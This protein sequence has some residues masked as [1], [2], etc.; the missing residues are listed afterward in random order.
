MLRV[1]L[2][3]E[4]AFSSGRVRGGAFEAWLQGLSS[5]GFE[6]VIS[7]SRSF[8]SFSEKVFER[9]PIGEVNSWVCLPKRFSSRRVP[10]GA[11]EAWFRGLSS[12]G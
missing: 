8:Q 6:D 12:F 3:P 2:S 11:F 1:G 7:L 5:F 9:G 4:K 10:G